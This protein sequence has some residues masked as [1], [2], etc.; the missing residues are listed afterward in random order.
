[1]SRYAVGI[2]LGGTKVE[3][4]LVDGT[5]QV[6]ARKRRPSEPGLGRERVVA[7]ILDLAAETAGGAS[8]EAVGL[9]TPGTYSAADDIMYGAPHT[10]LYEK[11]GLISRLRSRLAVPLIVENDANCLALA[12]FFAQC[13]GTYSTVMAVI[14]GTGMGSGLILENRL[15]RGP[16]GNAGEIG[17]TSI[18]I[19]GRVCECGRRGCGEAYLSG[20]SLGR[21]YAE[22]SGAVLAPDQIFA[23][24]EAGDPQAR[25]VFEESFRVM[26]ELFANCVNALDLEAIILGGGVS[27]IPLWYD[28]VPPVMNKAL[29]GI[30]GRRIPILKAVLGDSAGVL[31]AAYL[32]LREMRLMEF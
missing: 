15:H 20:P 8:Y 5:R 26:G 10:P 18:A 19:D 3:A 22:L 12:E 13:H 27:N 29:F 24:Y 21:R 14:L 30:P 31:G 11:P 16:N 1:M 28:N 23:R 2:D 9:G 4:C 7:N 25:R 32:A 6:L 17:H